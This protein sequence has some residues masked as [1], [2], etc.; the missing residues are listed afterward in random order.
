MCN[1]EKDM[2]IR[3]NTIERLK[4]VEIDEEK[5]IPLMKQIA[6]RYLRY[7]NRQRPSHSYLHIEDILG[8]AYEGLLSA[9]LSF[10]RYQQKGGQTEWKNYANT[11]IHGFLVDTFRKEY[12]RT[13]DK[14][15]KAYSKREVRLMRKF[16]E[17]PDLPNGRGDKLTIDHFLPSK[18]NLEKDVQ[19]RELVDIYID[20]IYKTAQKFFGRKNTS[21][22]VI[23]KRSKQVVNIIYLRYYCGYNMYEIGKKL[24]I[25][26]SRVSQIISTHIADILSL[27]LKED[28]KNR[29]PDDLDSLL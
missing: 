23:N 17:F 13:G 1:T 3:L 11:R 25:S 2:G 27:V 18:V 26:E 10:E 14:T 19:D 9:K 12:G 15:D 7:A 29:E 16:C 8:D 28:K 21:E 4:E 22:V 5:D 24:D 20:R 6:C